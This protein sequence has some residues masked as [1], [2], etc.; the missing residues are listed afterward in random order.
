[1]SFRILAVDHVQIAAPRGCE[2]AAR[3]FYGEILG[4]TELAKPA[5]LRARG[6]CWFQCGVQQLH[7][8]VED[9]FR[10]AKKA[11]P[12]FNVENL[13]ALRKSLLA[14]GIQAVNDAAIPGV[15]RFYVADP[16]GNRLEFQSV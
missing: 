2:P 11:H 5:E 12:A 3:K 9:D 8:G 16:F 13:D 15:N 4:M 7:I 14:A 6:G 1:V 10:P